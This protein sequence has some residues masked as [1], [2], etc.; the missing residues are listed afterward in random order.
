MVYSCAADD[1]CHA[2]VPCDSVTCPEYCQKRGYHYPYTTYCTPGQYYPNCCCRQLST[3]GD[4]C[5]LLLSN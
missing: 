3:N 5:R 4:V 1:F 2:V